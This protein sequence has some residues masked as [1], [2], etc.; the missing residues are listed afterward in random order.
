MLRP[1]P[2]GFGCIGRRGCCGPAQDVPMTKEVLLCKPYISMH[3]YWSSFYCPGIHV[4]EKA[5]HGD[6]AGH[7]PTYIKWLNDI[8]LFIT[9]IVIYPPTTYL[10]LG[11]SVCVSVC[12]CGGGVVCMYYGV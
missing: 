11:V 8:E 3:L 12:V 9:E 10:H 4:L 1:K 5:L 6:Y 7:R 2:V